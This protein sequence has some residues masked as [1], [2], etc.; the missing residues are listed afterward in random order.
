MSEQLPS[1][2]EVLG[3]M[4]STVPHQIFEITADGGLTCHGYS[5]DEVIMLLESYRE[6]MKQFTEIMLGLQSGQDAAH[7][8][9]VGPEDV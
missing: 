1:F 3:V 6:H 4:K 2:R 5:V 8:N 7:W 9:P